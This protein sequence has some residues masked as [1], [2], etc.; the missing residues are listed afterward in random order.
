MSKDPST[1]VGAVIVDPQTRIV[2][3]MGWNGF[4]RGCDDDPALYLDRAVKYPRTVHA[5]INAILNCERRPRGCHLYVW[6]LPPC[7]NC[8]SAI[9]QSGIVRVYSPPLP[10]DAGER[11]RDSCERAMALFAEAGVTYL[12][13]SAG[14]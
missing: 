3:G 4:P 10:A 11:W 6:P 5:E 7:D 9:V 2:I 13:E 14:G 8:S 1:A 12:A